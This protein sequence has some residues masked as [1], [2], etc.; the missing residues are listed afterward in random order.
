MQINKFNPLFFYFFRISLIIKQKK[1]FFLSAS[2]LPL[3]DLNQGPP[4]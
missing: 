4:D 1:H 2:V 3:L